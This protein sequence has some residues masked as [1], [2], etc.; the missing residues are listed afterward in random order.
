MA[1]CHIS[2][3]ANSSL[4]GNIAGTVLDQTGA[5]VGGTSVILFDA[6]GLEAQ[7][8]ITDQR[9][10]F[11]LEKVIA[12]D[13]VVSVPKNGFRE[14]RRVLR[15]TPGDSAA[16][17]C[18]TRSRLRARFPSKRASMPVS[19]TILWGSPIRI[20]G[21][22]SSILDKTVLN[23][24]KSAFGLLVAHFARYYLCGWTL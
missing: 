12:A 10:H 24:C 13:Y 6:A 2:A 19:T 7:R 16:R 23:L 17:S 8:S 1:L 20:A 22:A 18:V 15:V 11:T 5:S 21:G 9:G 3:R 4:S 14:L